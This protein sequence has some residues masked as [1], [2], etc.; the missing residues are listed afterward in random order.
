MFGGYGYGYG[1]RGL[2]LGPE[3]LLVIFAMIL[4][5]YAQGK[6]QSTFNKYS[7]LISTSG[8]N[9]FEVARR[10]LDRNGLHNVPIE[11]TPGR[12]SDHYDPRSRVLRLS[13][14]VYNGRSVASLG[15]AAH[16]VGHA[17]QH[18]TGYVPLT[19]RN[20]IAPAII[21]GSK[22]VWGIIFLGFFLRLTGLIQ[23]GIL[24]YV[25]IVAFQLITLPVEFDASNRAIQHL[26][27]GILSTS[28]VKPARKVLNAAALTYVAATLAS[29]AQLLRLIGM[30]NRRN[31]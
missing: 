8:Y 19:I 24:I 23:I 14:D 2:D 4:T 1:Y 5:F 12:L 22:F 11:M 27:N 6:V 31:D 7:R 30:S 13:S 25:G 26:E 17:I 29:I 28:E 20:S 18:A 16:E 15:V 9:G 10:I 21:A 3:I